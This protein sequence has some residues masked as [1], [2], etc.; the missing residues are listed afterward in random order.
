V[1]P[2]LKVNGAAADFSVCLHG[3]GKESF[4]IFTFIAEGR[5]NYFRQHQF[6]S[7]D[8]RYRLF[9]SSKRL[10]ICPVFVFHIHMMIKANPGSLAF[11]GVSL[12]KIRIRL[13]TRMFVSRVCC[14]LCW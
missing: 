2:R 8:D 9:Y 4:T 1:V 6:P 10:Y 5:G 14:V 11:Y 12:R 7:V 3:V 13:W